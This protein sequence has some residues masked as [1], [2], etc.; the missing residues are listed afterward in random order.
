MFP[1]YISL[2]SP[3]LARHQT[4]AVEFA[5]NVSILLFDGSEVYSATDVGYEVGVVQRVA[6]HK[7]ATCS[8]YSNTYINKAK[9]TC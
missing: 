5:T 3:S 2:V 4:N 1:R 8:A 6:P 7:L 9:A